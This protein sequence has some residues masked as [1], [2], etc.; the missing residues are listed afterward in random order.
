VGGRIAG[1]TPGLQ[2]GQQRRAGSAQSGFKP[3]QNRSVRRRVGLYRLEFL[4]IERV[5]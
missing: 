4:A 5:H 1:G 2:L 3:A